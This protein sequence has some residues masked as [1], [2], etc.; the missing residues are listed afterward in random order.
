MLSEGRDHTQIS[1]KACRAQAPDSSP[2]PVSLPEPLGAGLAGR[3]AVGV[4]RE[5]QGFL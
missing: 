4:G 2:E 5:A 3:E 1:G